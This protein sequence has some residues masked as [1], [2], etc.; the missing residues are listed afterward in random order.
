MIIILYEDSGFIF[1]YDPSQ[2]S[3]DYDQLVLCTHKHNNNI[4]VCR[5]KAE[6][7]H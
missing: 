7:F 3:S 5:N 6:R 1:L 4:D 2:N